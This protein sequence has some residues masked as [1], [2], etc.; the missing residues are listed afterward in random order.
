MMQDWQWAP[1]V[2]GLERFHCIIKWPSEFKSS[3]SGGILANYSPIDHTVILIART[4]NLT[5]ILCRDLQPA[6]M[7]YIIMLSA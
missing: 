4:M 1:M 3:Q 7:F 5:N 6:C 2:S